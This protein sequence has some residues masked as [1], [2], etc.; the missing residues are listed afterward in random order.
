MGKYI[1]TKN[2]QDMCDNQTTLI[3]ILNHRMTNMEG[4]V[5]IMKNDL[6][7][8]KIIGSSMCGILTAIF[9]AILIKSVGG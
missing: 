5:E 1:T 3:G 8:I 2:F 6:K 4:C 9:I 7:W